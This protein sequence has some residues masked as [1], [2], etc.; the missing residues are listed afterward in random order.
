MLLFLIYKSPP[1]GKRG[2]KASCVNDC[3]II[4]PQEVKNPVGEMKEL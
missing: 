1:N 2:D 3:T 4:S